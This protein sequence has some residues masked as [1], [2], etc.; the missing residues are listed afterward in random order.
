[1]RPRSCAVTS[2]Q[3]AKARRA[4][5]TALSTSAAPASGHFA[6]TSS[7]AGSITSNVFFDCAS[8]HSPS[9]SMR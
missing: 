5:W 4:A 8:T 2:R 7:R 9:I 3:A 6:M 1:M